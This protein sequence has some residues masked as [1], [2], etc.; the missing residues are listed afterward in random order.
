MTAALCRASRASLTQRLAAWGLRRAALWV[1]VGQAQSLS[2]WS[3]V[4][5]PCTACILS[6]YCLQPKINP[7]T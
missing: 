5:L 1:Q 7:L 4:Y 6:G 3:Q 2:T